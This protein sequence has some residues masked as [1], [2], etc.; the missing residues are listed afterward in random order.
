MLLY[1]A[2]RRALISFSRAA[3]DI[4]ELPEA[5]RGLYFWPAFAGDITRADD[6]IKHISRRRRVTLQKY[7]SPA[8][9][10]GLKCR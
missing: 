5:A 1:I 3:A 4:A 7:G 6:E 8:I 10:R 2:G 9:R